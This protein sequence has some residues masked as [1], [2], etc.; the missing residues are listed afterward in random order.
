MASKW[1]VSGL[2]NLS[3]TYLYDHPSGDKE[4]GGGQGDPTDD[5]CDDRD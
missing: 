4:V 3:I 5:N 2:A 1:L